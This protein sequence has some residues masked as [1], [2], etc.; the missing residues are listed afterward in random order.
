MKEVALVY[1][2]MSGNTEFAADFIEEGLLKK[3][4]SVKKTDVLDAD[5]DDIL[6]YENIAI[7][8]YTWGDGDVPDDALDFYEDMEETDLSGKQFLLFGTGDTAYADFC[9]AVDRFEE[10]INEQG[11]TVVIAPLKIEESPEG[12]EI[13]DTVNHGAA[14]G[15]KIS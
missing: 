13:T 9:G 8:V 11:G 4:V 5:S 3:G 1:A 12:Q 10:M 14:F 7:G 15:D 6:S 2:T